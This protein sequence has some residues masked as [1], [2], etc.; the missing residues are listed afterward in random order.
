MLLPIEEME[1]RLLAAGSDGLF[2]AVLRKFRRKFPECRQVGVVRAPGRVNII[3]EHTD[4]NGLPVMPMAIDREIVFA[5]SPVD[6]PTVEV[7]ALDPIYPKAVFMLSGS[8]PKFETGH[9]G[10]YIKA[11]AQATWNWASLNC[12]DKLPLS[13]IKGCIG[14]NIPPG[15]GLSSSSAVVVASALVFGRDLNID[16]VELAELLAKGERYVGTEGGGMD[17]AVSLMGQAGSAL[18]IDFFPLRVRPVSLPGGC[19]IA[20][21]NSMVTA[22]KTGTARIA[23]NTRVT[24]CRLGLELLKHASSHRNPRV[25]EVALLRDYVSLEP[26]WLEALDSLPEDPLTVSQVASIVGVAEDE[27]RRR[28]LTLRDGSLLPEPKDGFHPKKRCLHVLTEADRVERA[29]LAAECGDAAALGKLMNESHSSCAENYE[30]SCPELDYLVEV[31]R[32]RGALGAR[33][34]GAGFG[35]C[36]VALVRQ[37]QAS[38]LLDTVWTDYYERFLPTRGLP[39]PPKRDQ[40]LF[41]T[42]PVDGACIFGA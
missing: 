4:Y 32:Q 18:K 22:S 16:R 25:S 34:T 26:N 11:A 20:V 3:G 29:A 31:L 39:T 17:Q 10:N 40:V 2:L 30:I 41:V 1:K 28:C 5:F 7:V 42:K 36:A 38:D 21:A 23:F 8:I 13:G 14:G 33:L 37:E 9:W 35:G 12:P 19:L 6:S 15:A 27:L 24:E